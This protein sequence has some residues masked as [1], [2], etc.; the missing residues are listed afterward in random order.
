MCYSADAPCFA[1]LCDE[2]SLAARARQRA[3]NRLDA[4]AIGVGLNHGG[5]LRR[6]GAPGEFL[7]VG[8]DR[9]QV[10]GEDAASL[11]SGWSG[12]RETS[13]GICRY[14]GLQRGFGL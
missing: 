11:G 2:E 4:A 6:H 13:G 5:T 9:A 8:N 14:V 7:P 3:R 1:K 12:I 10:D